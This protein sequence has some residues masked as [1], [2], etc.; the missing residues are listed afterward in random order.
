MSDSSTAFL[1]PRLHLTETSSVPETPAHR[2]SF[3]RAKE[4]NTPVSDGG[5]NQEFDPNFCSLLHLAIVPFRSLSCLELLSPTAVG[6]GVG[7]EGCAGSNPG[8]PLETLE[9]L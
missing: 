2:Q 1:W 9:S 6:H 7:S 8:K 3:C 4:W 5:K